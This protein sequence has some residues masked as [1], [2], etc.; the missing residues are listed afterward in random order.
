M[1]SNVS[2]LQRDIAAVNESLASQPRSEYI[3]ELVH[4]GFAA[5]ASALQ[6]VRLDDDCIRITGPGPPGA[7]KRPMRFP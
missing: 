3:P 2:L 1:P 7:V 4:L 6:S 5:H